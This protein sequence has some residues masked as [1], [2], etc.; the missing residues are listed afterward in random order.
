MK[1]TIEKIDLEDIT[2][3]D[4]QQIRN[5]LNRLSKNSL[6]FSQKEY[7]KLHELDKLL[8]GCFDSFVHGV[9]IISKRG[10]E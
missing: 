9:H 1:A 6:A 4:A 3:D 7:P 5:E 8:A 2:R 10:E